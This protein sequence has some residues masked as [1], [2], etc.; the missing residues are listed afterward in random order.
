M[1]RRVKGGKTCE[2]E[3]LWAD[4]KASVQDRVEFWYVNGSTLEADRKEKDRR[5]RKRRGRE[6][7]NEENSLWIQPK[8]TVDDI[9]EF[10]YANR[11]M[12]EERT[13]DT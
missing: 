11:R 10:W 9:T 13:E 6:Q 3:S 8:V 5:R 7:D 2:K 1:K 12:K 4:P